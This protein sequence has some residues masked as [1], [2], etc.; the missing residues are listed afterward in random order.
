MNSRKKLIAAGV[1]VIGALAY[2]LVSGFTNHSLHD[3][4]VS[5]IVNNPVKYQGKGIKVSGTV[6]SGTVMKA[7][8]DL[9]FNMKDKNDDSF[10]KVEYKGIV[11][12]AFQEE[13]EVIV[14][15]TYD[16]ANKKFVANSLLAKCPSRYDGMDVK[17][18]NKAMAE[19]NADI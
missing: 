16:E 5:D 13:V 6:M 7:Q 14:E 2:L 11:P 1:V 4:E 15:G 10:I 8:L 19:M 3:A 12:D 17:E 18:H 9:A